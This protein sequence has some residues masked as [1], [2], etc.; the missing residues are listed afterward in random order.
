MFQRVIESVTPDEKQAENQDD[1][2]EAHGKPDPFGDGKTPPALVQPMRRV[3]PF[4]CHNSAI[5][6][7]NRAELVKRAD[8]LAG[9]LHRPALVPSLAEIFDRHHHVP[10]VERNVG[11][12]AEL[13]R[14][15]ARPDFL[16]AEM[17]GPHSDIKLKGKADLAEARVHVPDPVLETVRIECAHVPGEDEM[18]EIANHFALFF[19]ARMQLKHPRPEA[20]AVPAPLP[21]IRIGM[22]PAYGNYNVVAEAPDHELPRRSSCGQTPYRFHPER[23]RYCSRDSGRNVYWGLHRLQLDHYL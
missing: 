16:D 22:P 5:P 12:R 8:R 11:G 2:E 7:L 21:L 17:D 19:W 13:K 1:G 20:G 15:P 10:V 3:C 9:P 14:H 6:D 18:D 4:P 23:D